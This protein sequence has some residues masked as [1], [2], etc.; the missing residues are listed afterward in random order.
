[1]PST[2]TAANALHNH[3]RDDSGPNIG[4][5]KVATLK[6]YLAKALKHDKLSTNKETLELTLLAEVLGKQGINQLLLTKFFKKP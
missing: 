1:M 3:L 2:G 5:V 6:K 4:L